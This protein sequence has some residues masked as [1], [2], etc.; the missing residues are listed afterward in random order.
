MAA[1]LRA[2]AGGDLHEHGFDM[3]GLAD[4]LE[5]REPQRRQASGL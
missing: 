1:S 3:A 2:Q 5:V 4:D